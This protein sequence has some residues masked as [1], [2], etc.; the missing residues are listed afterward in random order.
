MEGLYSGRTLALA[1][2]LL[3]IL[4]LLL[5]V[6]TLILPSGAYEVHATNTNNN[7]TRGIRRDKG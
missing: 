3:P 2:P 1:L 5:L 7:K 4:S 6:G